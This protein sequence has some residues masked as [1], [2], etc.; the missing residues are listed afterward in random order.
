MPSLFDHKRTTKP[1]WSDPT[2]DAEAH[3]RAAGRTRYNRDRQFAALV[4]RNY[5][6]R[7]FMELHAEYGAKAQIAR[8]FGVAR[9]TVTRDIRNWSGEQQALC[10]TCLRPVRMDGWDALTE[11]RK[12]QYV[13]N[14][15]SDAAH[16][17]RAAIEAIREELPRVLADLWI[18]VNEP[19]DDEDD[20]DPHHSIFLPSVVLAD[21]VD[22]I[23]GGLKAA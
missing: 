9:S 5:V 12:H 11:A 18:F 13:E 2:S 23:A 16:A 19:E 15:L 1:S 4:R 14:P 3:A 20:E 10:P 17:R 6:V 7:R 22:R 8:E 21:M